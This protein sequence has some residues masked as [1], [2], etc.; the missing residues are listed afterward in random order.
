MYSLIFYDSYEEIFNS[1]T[2][3]YTTTN[4]GHQLLSTVYIKHYLIRQSKLR[5]DVE[6]QKTRVVVFKSSSDLV[7]ISTLSAQ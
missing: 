3:V 1:K 4:A 2:F 5:R 7:P 6:L